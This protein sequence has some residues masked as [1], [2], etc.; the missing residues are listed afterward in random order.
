MDC[1]EATRMSRMVVLTKAR[2][3]RQQYLC[4]LYRN[5]S[6]EHPPEYT[7]KGISSEWDIP[8]SKFV[9]NLIRDRYGTAKSMGLHEEVLCGRC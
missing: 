1:S 9:R 8:S 6:N 5:S 7:Q 4:C 3:L 2:L